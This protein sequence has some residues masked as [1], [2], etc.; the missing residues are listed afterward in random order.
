[1]VGAITGGLV[2][3]AARVYRPAS[4]N[5]KSAASLGLRT[6]RKLKKK[7]I[8]GIKSQGVRMMG[9]IQ[10]RMRGGKA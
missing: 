10:S 7:A 3:S 8:S 4:Q 1:M 6:G 2:A 9:A 5:A